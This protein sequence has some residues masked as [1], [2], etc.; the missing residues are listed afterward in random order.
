MW[1]ICYRVIA[2]TFRSL[3]FFHFF[4]IF[5]AQTRLFLNQ[6]KK[7]YIWVF[8]PLNFSHYFHLWHQ[9]YWQDKRINFKNSESCCFQPSILKR[10]KCQ[11]LEYHTN[12]MGVIVNICQQETPKLY[13]L[14]RTESANLPQKVLVE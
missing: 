14:F 3:D 5:S 11:K 9:K 6:K 10:K 4:L 2:A 13:Q 8:F 1:I 7:K 12:S